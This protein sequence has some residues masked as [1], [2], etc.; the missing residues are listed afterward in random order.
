MRDERGTFIKLYRKAVEN[1][2]FEEKP[3][4]RWHAFEYMLIR[5]ST[6]P[7]TKIFKGHRVEIGRG[8]LVFG[9]AKM[10]EKFGWSRNKLIR[11]LELLKECG[12]IQF[13][14]TP[15]GTHV[16]IENYTFYQDG[17][18]PNGTPDGTSNGTPDG[19]SNGTH[20]KKDKKVKKEK[21]RERGTTHPKKPRGRKGNVLLTDEDYQSIKDKYDQHV[22]LINKVD[23][24]LANT[25]RTYKDHESLIYRIAENDNWPTKRMAEPRNLELTPEEIRAIKEQDEK[26]R[27][28]Q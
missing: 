23:A 13:R 6:F 22:K 26:W 12:M 14:G 5:A 8:E 9:T 3:F 16:T 11:F 18:T 25:E 2:L 24:Y 19:T 7:E 15:Y 20:L 10:A 1:E 17:Q 21:N 28:E 4:D 27:N